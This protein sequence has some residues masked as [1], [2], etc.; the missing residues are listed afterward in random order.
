MLPKCGSLPEFSHSIVADIGEVL[1]VVSLYKV[2]SEDRHIYFFRDGSVVFWNV[3]ELERKN[4]LQ[5]LKKYSLGDLVSE[6]TMEE[7][8]ET[9]P[10]T[11]VP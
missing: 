7:Q 11:F 4:V 9:L 2:S 10:F 6:S 1:H 3:D 5:F 8:G